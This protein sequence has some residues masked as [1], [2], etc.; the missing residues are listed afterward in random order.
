MQEESQA[1]TMVLQYVQSLR[2]RHG[3]SATRQGLTVGAIS[4]GLVYVLWALAPQLAEISK[5][6]EFW[7]TLCL[8]FSCSLLVFISSY[9]LFF[10]PI[11]PRRKT[12][13][14]YRVDNSQRSLDFARSIG[15]LFVAFLFPL[16]GSWIAKSQFFY[17]GIT[18]FQLYFNAVYWA[19]EGF[20]IATALLVDAIYRSRIGMPVP[21]TVPFE[22]HSK[23]YRYI[24]VFFRMLGS[25]LYLEIFFGNIA[26]IFLQLWNSS[27]SQPTIFLA[28]L[29]ISIICFGFL[30][31]LAATSEKRNI[32]I[33]DALE[34]D[35][36]LYNMNVDDA[37]KILEEELLGYYF[38]SWLLDRIKKVKEF[39]YELE[40]SKQDTESLLTS[41]DEI[42]DDYKYEKKGRVEVELKKL[43]LRWR[44]YSKEAE[45]LVKWLSQVVVWTQSA[46]DPILH[47]YINKAIDEI[48]EIQ[49][50]TRTSIEHVT[51]EYKE[52]FSN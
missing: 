20:L 21:M 4:F 39:S 32:S 15:I 52:Y 37:R 34:R 7:K 48:K 46:G 45:K 30:L 19:F 14:D 36:S 11:A 3:D 8:Y 35:L 29:N 50:S 22:H 44:N 51:A 33:L 38:G 9:F 10:K 43:E 23:T 12:L 1:R 13:F 26:V 41:L 17:A 25:I 47:N 42:P 28:G 27:V 5:G 2:N 6:I 16:Y 31:L 24:S 40:K 49:S 18:Y